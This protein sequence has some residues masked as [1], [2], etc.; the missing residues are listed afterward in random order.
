MWYCSLL[1]NGRCDDSPFTVSESCIYLQPQTKLLKR[2]V[3]VLFSAKRDIVQ[4][5]SIE[6]HKRAP[7]TGTQIIIQSEI[8]CY[9]TI[10]IDKANFYSVIFS[11]FF[12]KVLLSH[13]LTGAF[14]HFFGIAKSAIEYSKKNTIIVSYKINHW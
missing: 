6:E 7:N 14:L 8:S 12:F 4:T 10:T 1:S 3:C 5:P 13:S 11:S 9:G 2:C